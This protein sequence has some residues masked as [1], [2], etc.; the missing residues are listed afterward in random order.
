MK[1]K[2][3]IRPH[4]IGLKPYVSARSEYIGESIL[5]DANEN[6]LGS[7]DGGAHNRYPD[8]LQKA[9][10]S[11]LITWLDAGLSIHHL[12]LGNGSDETLDQLI[13]SFCE[14]GRDEI[15]ICPPTFGMFE[16]SAQINNVKVK[17]VDLVEG[18]QLDLPAI[19][20]EIWEHLKIIFICSP[21]NPTGNLINSEDIKILLDSFEGLLVVDEAYFD[22]CNGTS[23]MNFLGRYDNLIVTRTFSKAWGMAS[24]RLGML[25][26]HPDVISVLNT[27]KMPYNINTSTMD[28]ALKALDKVDVMERMVAQ[29]NEHKRQLSQKIG[30]MNMVEKVYPSDTNYLLV[31]FKDCAAVFEHLKEAGIVVRD[32]S[33]QPLC[34]GCLRI[35]V[36]NE[37]E[38]ELVLKALK[39]FEYEATTNQE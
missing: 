14:P 10:K 13:R 20:E 30:W 24:V 22:F 11:K 6:A 26:A 34:S 31:K 8:P 38:N 27:I 9:L 36:G 15:L 37:E 16:K 1:I 19:K 39:D 4:L 7:V 35:T 25:A 3:L 12:F 5:L 2:E 21:N 23:W 32:R 18:F 17:K 29:L 33:S 28:L